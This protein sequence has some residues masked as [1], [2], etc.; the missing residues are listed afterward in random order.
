M[1]DITA[2][3]FSSA[4]MTLEDVDDMLLVGGMTRAPAVY[5]RV[6]DFFQRR[7]SRR[8]NP[9]EAVALGAAILASELDAGGKL[10]LVDVVPLS[11]GISGEGRQFK[12]LIPRNSHVPVERSLTLRTTIDN[13]V[14]VS[15]PIFQGEHTDAA[16][17]EYL[18]TVLVMDVPIGPA[19]THAFEVKLALDQHCVLSARAWE[20]RSRVE[21]PVRLDRD[22]PLQDILR[23]L[24]PY[25]G[26]TPKEPGRVR[27]RSALADFFSKL[28]FWR[29]KK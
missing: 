12:R 19:G 9:D 4:G 27:K 7:P 17:N 14:A 5:E 15:M 20:T 24:G 2:A 10:T 25:K 13:Q 16:Q 29:R 23:E 11:I 22:R 18:G 28:S 26:P 6:E 21:V 8:I 1:I 3:V